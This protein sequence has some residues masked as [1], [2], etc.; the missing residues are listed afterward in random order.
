M[1]KLPLPVH[2]NQVTVKGREYFYF[3]PF[4]GTKREGKSIPLPGCPYLPSG[5]PNPEWW[6][7]YRA[8]SGAKMVCAKAGSFQA[9]ADA[10]SGGSGGH[11][12]P[13]WRA[14]RPNTQRNYRTALKRI[15]LAWGNLPVRALEPKY[16]LELR[17]EL[18]DIPQAANTL[19]T[20]LSSMLQWSI[21]RGWR[22]TNPCEH[23]KPFP[24]GD[25]WAPWSIEAI[26][27]W[28]DLAV[29]QMRHAMMLGLYTGQR[30]SDV[31]PMNWADVDRGVIAVV[32][33][34]TRKKVWIP[35]HR[36][37]RA[38]LET[39]E[40]CSTKILTGERGRPWKLEG[41]KTVWGR[42][43]ECIELMT[44][45]CHGLVFHGLRKSA[46]CFMLDAGCSIEEVMA[47][48]GQSRQMVEYYASE[49]NRQRL[50]QQAIAK[51]EARKT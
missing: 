21:P 18:Q 23:V 11:P 32:Q 27:S 2:V 39:T 38:E 5:E 50:G 6:A 8:A 47:I 19:L 28:R 12:S 10:W 42:Q 34:K 31:L 3:H 16:V 30:C 20:A 17:D 48:T 41:F 15:L 26:G 7:A 49:L 14:L 44:G 22:D 51:W 45:A 35:L 13:E 1:P 29:P 24:P 40:R 33:E 25:P 37:L 36:D 43:M 9:L 4:R 46:V